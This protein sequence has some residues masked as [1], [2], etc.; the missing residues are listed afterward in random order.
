MAGPHGRGDVEVEGDLTVRPCE[1]RVS[2]AREVR[3]PRRVPLD[4]VDLEVVD[5]VGA[6]REDSDGACDG[7]V[8]HPYRAAL[9]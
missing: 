2:E 4:A 1:H 7:R 6:V 3:L 8:I 9:S 5:A